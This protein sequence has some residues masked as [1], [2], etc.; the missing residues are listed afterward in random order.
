[1]VGVAVIFVND[2]LGAD[3]S[4]TFA[5]VGLGVLRTGAIV[6][7]A[8]AG[9]GAVAVGALVVVVVGTFGATCSVGNSKSKKS[10]IG[11]LAGT[12]VS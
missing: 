7:G 8:G 9:A 4:E 10:L 5:A 1:M 11:V 3:V 2:V 6:A 12:R